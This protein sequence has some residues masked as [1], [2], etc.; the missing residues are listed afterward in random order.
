MQAPLDGCD[1][2][3]DIGLLLDQQPVKIQLSQPSFEHSA[4][5]AL[6]GAAWDPGHG[7]FPW[8]LGKRPIP[9]A[10]QSSATSTCWKEVQKAESDGGRLSSISAA[11]GGSQQLHRG[12]V[13]RQL[14]GE[15]FA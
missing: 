11:K 13:R 7:P 1:G 5:V 14:D 12:G 2:Q 4:H 8:D 9:S 15:Q 6:P 10:A 3:A